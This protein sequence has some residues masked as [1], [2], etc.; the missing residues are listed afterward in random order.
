M[1]YAIVA[2]LALIVFSAWL[3][4][5]VNLRSHTQ[6]HHDH[7]PNEPKNKAAPPSAE[8]HEVVDLITG[9]TSSAHRRLTRNEL[10]ADM[11]SRMDAV[12]DRA[13]LSDIE[14]RQWDHPRG[15]WVLAPNS[16]PDKRLLYIHGGAF[17]AG[18]PRSHRTITT[19]YARQQGAAVFAVDYRLLPEHKRLDCL[20]DCRVA[21]RWILQ[22]GP[23]GPGDA[24]SIIVSGDSAGGNLTLVI[25][26][27]A[28]DEGLR[29]PDSVIAI[30][31]LTDNTF[32]SPT[33]ISNIDS[34][35]LLGRTL[36]RLAGAPKALTYWFN[37]LSARAKPTDP[38]LSPLHGDLTGLPPTLI[39]ASEAELLLGDARRYANKAAA[40]GSPVSLA[41]WEHM[42][43]VWHIFEPMLPEAQQAFEH[44]DDFLKHNTAI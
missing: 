26:A 29:R 19:K 8:H 43:H 21:Y 32:T 28:R 31:P 22:N 4:A 10:I 38:R 7:A 44:I 5:Y 33:L 17:M 23:E 41:T 1:M 39:H 3:A 20:E 11:R 18:S 42:V 35:P 40:A 27:W 9:M 6:N 2:A 12:G 37:W 16:D 13:D 14:I 34:D 30:A 25:A 15:E 24:A 36:G